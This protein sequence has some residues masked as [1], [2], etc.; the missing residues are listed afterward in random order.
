[1]QA[2]PESLPLPATGASPGTENVQKLG[3]CQFVAHVMTKD[4]GTWE[5]NSHS[6]IRI[7]PSSNANENRCLDLA[8]T[9]RQIQNRRPFRFFEHP[10][11]LDSIVGGCID[12]GNTRFLKEDKVVVT[13]RGVLTRIFL[14]EAVNLHV[15]YIDGRM[16]IE[17]ED[18][19]PQ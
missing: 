11:H 4:D 16:Y 6:P 9:V 10:K 12:S 19:K 17:E 15:S 13:W 3:D 14:G 18:P 8:P 7:F 5:V 1:M 2:A